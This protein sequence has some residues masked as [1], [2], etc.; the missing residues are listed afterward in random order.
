MDWKLDTELIKMFL[1]ECG[2][3]GDKW[4]SKF[5]KIPNEERQISFDF[6][7]PVER[8]KINLKFGITVNN[9]TLTEV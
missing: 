2:T 3:D 6:I 7:C 9:V 1:E 5:N 4:E 8:K